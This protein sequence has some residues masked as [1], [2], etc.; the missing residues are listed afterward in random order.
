[1]NKCEAG[2]WN[3][4]QTGRETLIY[5]N[6]NNQAEWLSCEPLINTKTCTLHKCRCAR[7][8]LTDQGLIPDCWLAL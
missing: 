5:F 4:D 6:C 1:M 8:I 2:Y 3:E 7:K